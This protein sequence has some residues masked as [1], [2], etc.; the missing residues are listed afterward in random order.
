MEAEAVE[1][2]A[3][4]AADTAVPKPLPDVV[5]RL[6]AKVTEMCEAY[7]TSI[8]H[9]QSQAP[10]LPAGSAAGAAAGPGAETVA[11]FASDVTRLHREFD[12][13]V[14]ELESQQCSESEQLEAIETLQSELRRADAELRTEAAALKEIGWRRSE[15]S[16]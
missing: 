6:H 5:D 8:G 12:G 10:P 15:P 3:S 4:S 11:S 16:T 13:L 9:L 14:D 7:F 1:D 2:R